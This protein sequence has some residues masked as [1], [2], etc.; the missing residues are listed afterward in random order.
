MKIFYHRHFKKSFKRLSSKIQNRFF[1]RLQVFLQN[2]LDPSLNNHA[3]SGEYASFRSLNITGDMRA[4]FV[5]END[6]VIFHE[7]G[8]HHQLYE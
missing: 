7:I 4:L 6:A 1:E 2:P 3:L 5:M 8:T